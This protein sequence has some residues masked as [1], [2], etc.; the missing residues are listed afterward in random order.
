MPTNSNADAS[1]INDVA[2]PSISGDISSNV[3]NGKVLQ[4]TNVD[5]EEYSIRG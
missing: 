1:S 5:T 3:T 4:R 2:I